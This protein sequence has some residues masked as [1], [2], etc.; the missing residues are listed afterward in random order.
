MNT[1]QDQQ[2]ESRSLSALVAKA[3]QGDVASFKEL[4]QL[5]VGP[6]CSAAN[7]LTEKT[8]VAERLTKLIFIRVWETLAEVDAEADFRIWMIESMQDAIWD[9]FHAKKTST[10]RS[11]KISSTEIERV[12]TESF[13]NQDDPIEPNPALWR[14]I[15]AHIE[16]EDIA[17][18]DRKKPERIFRF[19]YAALLVVI[20]VIGQIAYMTEESQLPSIGLAATR[21]YVGS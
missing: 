4:Y 5:H 14:A 9:Q 2:A 1:P 17:P 7:A 3:Q 13:S 12:V 6:V 16:T 11:K 8:S 15:Q 21:G 20:L 18:V 19:R 10:P